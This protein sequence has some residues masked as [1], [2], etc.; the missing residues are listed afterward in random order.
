MGIRLYD[1]QERQHVE[2]MRESAMANSYEYKEMGAARISYDK[3]SAVH[4]VSASDRDVRVELKATESDGKLV[5]SLRLDEA[6][7]LYE[8]LQS[9]CVP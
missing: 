7:R 5:V 4:E 8:K 3:Y 6:R 1:A 9:L 2:F